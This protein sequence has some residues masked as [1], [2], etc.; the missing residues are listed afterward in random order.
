MQPKFDVWFLLDNFLSK[1][2]KYCN[3]KNSNLKVA[4]FFSKQ[5][6]EYELPTTSL[7]H[8]REQSLSE[9]ITDISWNVFLPKV[10]T[11]QE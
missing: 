2:T 3:Q 7:L 11:A 1:F 6:E 4:I 8:E 5:R 10:M 9:M